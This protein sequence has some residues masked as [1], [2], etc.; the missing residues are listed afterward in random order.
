MAPDTAHLVC[1]KILLFYFTDPRAWLEGGLRQ[2]HWLLRLYKG[3]QAQ[4]LGIT[5]RCILARLALFS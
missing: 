1:V 5:T 4:P 3:G 2:D